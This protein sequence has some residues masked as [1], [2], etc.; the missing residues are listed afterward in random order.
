MKMHRISMARPFFSV[1][2]ASYNY[3]RLIMEPSFACISAKL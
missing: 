3:E 1:V 2:V